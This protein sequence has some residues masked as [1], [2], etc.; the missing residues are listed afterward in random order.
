VA[1][2]TVGE[3]LVAGLEIVVPHSFAADQEYQEEM[4]ELDNSR[5]TLFSSLAF[6]LEKECFWMMRRSM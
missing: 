6:Y 4:A 3:S 1:A 5:M 2:S